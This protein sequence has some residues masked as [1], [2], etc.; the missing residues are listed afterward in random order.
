MVVAYAANPLPEEKAE[1][2]P[3]SVAAEEEE[4]RG[5]GTK[6]FVPND[7][8]CP[9]AGFGA[10]NG[11]P[12]AAG[13]PKVG[14][15]AKSEAL[16]NDDVTVVPP[17]LA[18]LIPGLEGVEKGVSKL[19]ENP[20]PPSNILAGGGSIE[21]KTL[22][23][24]PEVCSAL[25]VVMVAETS[26]GWLGAIS[27]TIAG[28]ENKLGRAFSLVAEPSMP[29]D[30]RPKECPSPSFSPTD[31]RLPLGVG[32]PAPTSPS[33]MILLGESGIIGGASSWIMARTFSG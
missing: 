20:D 21:A 10:P 25:S 8:V 31:P 13:A 23:R 32:D 7:V 24:K 2:P 5:A 18:P 1:N 27:V 17:R 3:E 4:W 15:A 6:G 9:K 14:W 16:P 19:D 33:W 11:I 22:G 29:R 12:N 30:K 26:D 28:T